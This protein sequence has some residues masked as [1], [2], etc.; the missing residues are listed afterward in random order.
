MTALLHKIWY[1]WYSASLGALA[2]RDW[3]LLLPAT[4]NTHLWKPTSMKKYDHPKNNVLWEP[5]AYEKA[6]KDEI[7]C[8]ARETKEHWGVRCIHETYVPSLKWIASSK[9]P[10]WSTNGSDTGCP[11]EIIL[12]VPEFSTSKIWANEI[13]VWDTKF[14]ASLL[15][16]N[17]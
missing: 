12:K 16:C 14:C 6:L 9:D 2:I 5:K 1:K 3:Q 7:P 8:G 13:V 11:A 4:C 17:R 10:S 15:S